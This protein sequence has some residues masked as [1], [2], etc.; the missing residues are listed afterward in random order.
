MNL[1]TPIL[2][3]QGW[4]ESS[5]EFHGKWNGKKSTESGNAY[6]FTEYKVHSCRYTWRTG[7]WQE[8]IRI[9]LSV[10]K[11]LMKYVDLDEPTSFIDHVC[12]GQ[13]S[14]KSDSMVL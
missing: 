1:S 3:D 8:R 10:R 12:L 13:T 4:K 14:R 6:L 11:K 7:N 9:R 5:I 2:Q